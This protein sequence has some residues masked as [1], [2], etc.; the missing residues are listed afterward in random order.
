MPEYLSPGVYFESISGLRAIEGVSTSTAGFVGPAERGPVAGFPLPFNPSGFLALT[1]DPAPLLVT[2]FNEFTRV[3][4]NALP[5][6]KAT[7]TDDT[8]YLAY[9]V[10]SFFN[11][12]GKRAYVAR[13]VHQGAAGGTNNATRS[14]IQLNQGTVWRLTQP[15]RKGDST[16]TVTSVRGLNPGDQILIK[17]RSTGELAFPGTPASVTGNMG[18]YSLANGDRF[19]VKVDAGPQV[20]SAV[21][22]QA[23][24]AVIETKAGPFTLANGQSLDI[25]VGPPTAP[26]QTVTLKAS[27]F[28][29]IAQAKSAE[30][31]KVFN[32]ELTGIK[33]GI[34]SQEN[35]SLQIATV[36]VGA[37]AELTLVSG[38]LFSE[39]GLKLPGPMGTSIGLNTTIYG[40]GNIPDPNNASI[41]DV[42]A[43]FN[44]PPT[45]FKITDDGTGR[46]RIATTT[47]G[48][49]VELKLDDT[50]Q[51]TLAKLKLDNK[52]VTGTDAPVFNVTTTNTQRNQFSL[53]L[54]LTDN[55][56]PGDVY[57]GKPGGA[58]N[59]ILLTQQGPKFYARN[60]GFWSKDLSVMVTP[61]ERNPV[62]ITAPAQQGKKIIQVQSPGSFYRGAILEID[63]GAAGQFKRSCYEIE[64]IQGNLL[65][66]SSDLS[67]PVDERSLARVL[68]IR[69]TITDGTGAAPPEVFDGLCWNQKPNADPRRHYAT[70]INASSR[71]VYVQP[72]GIGTPNPLPGSENATLQTQPTTS[73]GFPARPQSTAIG[74][75]GFPLAGEQGDD[76]YI[77]KDLGPGKRS[78]IQSLKDVDDVRIVAVPGRTTAKVQLELITHCELLRHRFAVLDG[79]RPTTDGAVSDLLAHRSLYD[80]SFAAYYT[81]WVGERV[82]NE[83]VYLPPSGYVA[84]V[85]ARTD[86]ERGVHKAPANEVARNAAALESYFTTGEQDVLN[87]RGVNA[88][89]RFD[90]RGIRV[91]GARTLS[92]DPELRYVNVQRFLIFLEA[93]IDRGTQYVVF[94]PNTPETWSRVVDSISAFLNT[95]WRNGALFGRRAEEAYFVRCDESTMTADDIQ[96]GRLICHIGVAIVRPA[97]F[98]IFR[99]EQITGFGKSS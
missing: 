75:D 93:S 70:Q 27:D 35:D 42:A 4:G 84:G 62:A 55:L 7:D 60:P 9:A 6:P 95:Q 3:F 56:D 88:I 72:P 92:S 66:L 85:Y 52:A 59:S 41:T 57:I 39:L 91:W 33:V 18:P 87:P 22:K 69:I 51:G 5:V 34:P 26:I 49:A 89:R 16:L 19:S 77:G 44:P 43:L 74:T 73:D 64:D 37:S 30:L 12:G 14:T 82:G 25:R 53:N 23:T 24:P 8:G 79:T 86:N 45:N 94:S 83:L 63:H 20:V 17:R 76:D 47:T 80:S 65:T 90:G 46:I 48:A 78:G 36:A 29:S 15:A 11:N 10:K 1:A 96:N 2:S 40:D 32:R 31:A 58:G 81:P 97:E 13:V 54:S 68:E 50:V 61:T 67:D 38:L 28:A 21:V 98:V 71:L 99:I